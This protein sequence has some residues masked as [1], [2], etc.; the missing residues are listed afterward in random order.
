MPLVITKDSV[1][2]FEKE[3]LLSIES[4]FTTFEPLHEAVIRALSQV[5]KGFMSRYL[6]GRDLFRKEE[7]IRKVL[8][9]KDMQ[10][11]VGA[12]CNEQKMLYAFDQIWD[13]RHDP[14]TL[15]PE[16]IA[17]QEM[18]SVSPLKLGAILCIE[19]EGNH[20]LFPKKPNDI[21]FFDPRRVMPWNELPKGQMFLLFAFAPITAIYKENPLDPNTNLL[22]RLD[23]Q[24]NCP[25]NRKTHPVFKC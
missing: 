11:I 9:K 5:P 7:G 15:F 13:V 2:T 12:L 20:E 19:G 4:F 17:L 21:L 3:G 1:N 6:G 24:P 23:Y 8:L 10:K 18:M 22:K 25:L 14:S 16:P